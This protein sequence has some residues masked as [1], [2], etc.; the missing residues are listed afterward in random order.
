MVEKEKEETAARADQSES[1]SDLEKTEAPGAFAKMEVAA[2]SVRF[3]DENPFSSWRLQGAPFQRLR[4][5][6]LIDGDNQPPAPVENFLMR[7]PAYGN[8]TMGRVFGNWSKPS[9]APWSDFCRRTGF[10]ARQQHDYVKGKNAT[11]IALTIDAMELAFD[12]NVEG[13]VLISADSDFTPL[14]VRLR[15]L[16]FVVI[17]AGRAGAPSLEAACTRY[18]HLEGEP[19]VCADSPGPAPGGIADASTISTVPPE[20]QPAQKWCMERTE[21]IARRLNARKAVDFQRLISGSDN[22]RKLA[23]H[24]V[25]G[26]LWA[27]C[28]IDGWTPVQAVGFYVC[29]RL[30]SFPNKW[31]GVKKITQF[32]KRNHK[33]YEVRGSYYRLRPAWYDLAPLAD[34]PFVL[35]Q[36]PV[37]ETGG[38][39]ACGRPAP[40]VCTEAAE[41]CVVTFES[42]SVQA[43]LFE[44]PE[45]T[46]P[47]AA[48][49]KRSVHRASP[50]MIEPVLP[51]LDFERDVP[52]SLPTLPAVD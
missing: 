20:T 42:A 27:H 12:R 17:G 22:I 40:A 49:V 16:G 44:L 24:K 19:V 48:K 31:I 39:A 34:F 2:S 6:V 29:R 32:F 33:L 8:V 51:G 14:A 47:E 50:P 36:R 3:P 18:H 1:A 45:E 13:F 26:E 5:A 23:Y 9:L 25:L 4:L 37:E 30:G 35:P 11:D 10:G 28:R 46:P 7:L 21:E 15:E 52:E 38:P 41:P 43:T